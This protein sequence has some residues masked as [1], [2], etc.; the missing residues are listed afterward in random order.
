M[1]SRHSRPRR[2]RH[3]RHP[4]LRA[5]L[6]VGMGAS[7]LG[8]VESDGAIVSIDL[9]PSGFNVLGANA[10]ISSGGYRNVAN[11]PISNG[12]P[13]LVL[14]NGFYGWV[15]VSGN[16][17]FNV[18]YTPGVPNSYA[19]PKKFVGGQTIDG[20]SSFNFAQNI[21][22]FKVTSYVAPDWG[23]GSYLGFQVKDGSDSYYG[24]L[25]ATWST[26]TNTFELLSGAYESTPNTP[27]TTPAAL[28]EPS[29]IAL[30]GIGALAVGAGAIRRSRKAR[31]E[32]VAEAV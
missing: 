3:P 4:N 9:G 10:G 21:A 19:S 11:F 29:T 6:A 31:R 26:S 18:A 12:S 2:T 7:V 8:T 22:N 13:V 28:P 30:T 27:I 14:S 1:T 5:Y 23:P 20:S 24:Y 16:P 25:E 32:P 17:K 15:G